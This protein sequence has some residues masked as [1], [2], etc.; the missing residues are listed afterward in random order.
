MAWA[1]KHGSSWRVRYPK[2]DGTLGSIPGF[3]TKTAAKNYADDIETDQ[4]KGNWIDPAAGKITLS[5]WVDDWL[6]ALDVRPNTENQYRSLLNNHIL[7]KWGDSPLAEITGIGIAAWTKKLAARGYKPSTVGHIR[8]VFSL[9]LTDAVD[10]RLIP[11]NPVRTR[12]RRGKRLHTKRVERPWATPEQ[13]LLIADHAANLIGGWAGVLITTAAYT[14]ARW[15]ELA[16][17]QRI[18][19][20]LDDATIV[21]DPDIGALHELNGHFELG[22]PKTPES[23]RT[24]TLPPFLTELLRTHL[25]HH[26]HPHIFVSAEQTY[27][28]RSNFNRRA[29]RPAADGNLHRTRIPLRVPP[30]LPGLAF[31]DL[32]HSHKTWLITDAIPEIAQAC[33]LGHTLQNPMQQTYSHVSSEV[34]HRTITALQDRWDKTLANAP[35]T[36]LDTTWRNLT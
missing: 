17:L 5:T 7:P 9:I 15:G 35:A 34:E 25:D 13:A 3:A 24:I 20:H 16:G 30:V 36:T 11:S 22:P 31:H 33:R 32:R 19:T 27:L 2:K 26:D 29:M 4:R 14:G 6:D 21:I 28:R 18:N 8:K 23:A 12:G 10:D 1:E